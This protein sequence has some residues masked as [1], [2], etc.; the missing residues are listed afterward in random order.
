MLMSDPPGDL[1]YSDYVC[2]RR[3][4][5]QK[6]D[7][8]RKGPVPLDDQVHNKQGRYRNCNLLIIPDS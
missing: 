1:K 5:K 8:Y 6:A 3:R 4:S 7:S 2:A